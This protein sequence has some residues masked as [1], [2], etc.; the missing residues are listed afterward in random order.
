MIRLLILTFVPLLLPFAA[1]Y[2]WRVFA[3]KP[4]IDPQT[5][6]QIPPDFAKA[7]VVK[8]LILG[9]VLMGITIGGFLL[10]HSWISEE[11]YRPMSVDE[12][13][14]RLQQTDRP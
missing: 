5:G 4:K 2:A 14:R 12:L 7:P 9:F 3:E 1:W 10:A 11:P 13:E 6:E 8:L